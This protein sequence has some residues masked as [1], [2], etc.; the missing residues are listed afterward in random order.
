VFSLRTSPPVVARLAS[1]TLDPTTQRRTPG[2]ARELGLTPLTDLELTQGSYQLSLPLGDGREVSYP[3]VVRRGAALTLDIPLPTPAS[4]PPGFIHVPAGEFLFG[5]PD[6]EIIRRFFT[7][8]PQHPVR[9]AAYQIARSETTYAEWLTFL[10]ALPPAERA[11]YLP[12]SGT[13]LLGA[14]INLTSS[15]EGVWSLSITAGDQTYRAVEGEPIV[16]TSRGANA[17]QD[18]LK[19]PASGLSVADAEAY[20]AW[21]ARTARV[22]RARLC[23]DWEWERAARGADGRRYPSGDRIDPE[24]VNIDTTYGKLAETTGPDEVGLHPASRSQLGLDD[25][26]GNVWEWVRSSL[27]PTGAVARGGAFAYDDVTGLTVNRMLLP[28]NTRDS[29]VGLRVCATPAP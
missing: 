26:T 11:R 25:T 13:M 20:V 4:V 28:G 22:P 12:T 16:Y 6:D 8:A 27:A 21:L 15:K 29:T 10:R 2:E 9:T 14:G 23:T 24:D 19:M 3:F 18:W 5:S 17:R 1:V 7:T